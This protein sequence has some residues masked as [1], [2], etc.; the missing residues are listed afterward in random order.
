MS[1]PWKR[2]ASQWLPVLPASPSSSS[3]APSRPGH[4][5]CARAASATRGE[6]TSAVRAPGRSGAGPRGS[7]PAY[8]G[9]S[10]GEK[11]CGV[12]CARVVCKGGVQR[13]CDAQRTP[14][15]VSC[16]CG[17]APPLSQAPAAVLSLAPSPSSGCGRQG[18]REER[19]QGQP[20]PCVRAAAARGRRAATHKR[21][22]QLVRD[23]LHLPPRRQP[24]ERA[25]AQVNRARDRAAVGPADSARA[26][27]GEG[28]AIAGE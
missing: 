15:N 21:V 13:A 2:R 12:V 24:L 14:A 7:P 25:W 4:P 6:R 1:S 18:W 5:K 16:I 28:R 3:R 9:N 27:V 11:P 10:A 19:P 23:D 26:S 20:V 17:R 22:Q 8:R